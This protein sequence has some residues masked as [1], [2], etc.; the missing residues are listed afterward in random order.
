MRSYFSI[1]DQ[2]YLPVS[3]H[4]AA[5]CSTTPELTFKNL[6]KPTVQTASAVRT[7]DTQS[8]PAA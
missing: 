3:K 8:H 5:Y 6:V 4:S 2:R 7:P 1:S